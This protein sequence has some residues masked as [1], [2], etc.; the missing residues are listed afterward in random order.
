M[1]ARRNHVVFFLT[2]LSFVSSAQGATVAPCAKDEHWVRAHNRRAYLRG[3]GTFVSA[4]NVSAHCQKNPPSYALWAPK[5]QSGM[6]PGWLL[7]VEKLSAWTDEEKE[8]VLEAL[9]FLPEKLLVESVQGLYRLRKSS[10]FESNPGAGFANSIVLYDSAFNSKQ[11]LSRIL[12]HEFAH[13]LYHR[14][15]P[16]DARSY[17]AAAEWGVFRTKGGQTIFVPMR[18]SYVEDDGREG[19][20]EDFSNNIEYYLFASNTLKKGTPKV[21][22]WILQKYGE[23]FKL[24]KASKK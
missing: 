2:V 14:L 4:A 24:K 17:N 16:E 6:P 1:P 8:R 9:S 7:Q 11:D 21:S 12:A 19:P 3:D 20:N 13:K 5:L 10:S 22:E 15:T 23:A 18:E